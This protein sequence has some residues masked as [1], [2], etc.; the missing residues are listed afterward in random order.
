MSVV[1]HLD[2]WKGRLLHLGGSLRRLAPKT[3]PA[4]VVTGPV[5]ACLRDSWQKQLPT[6][7]TTSCML[8]RTSCCCNILL[9]AHNTI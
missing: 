3:P 8:F 1:V 2:N 7:M 4:L 6:T 9:L 5:S